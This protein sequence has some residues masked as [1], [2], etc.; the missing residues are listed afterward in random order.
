MI[1]QE[2]IKISIKP[3]YSLYSLYSKNYDSKVIYVVNNF[4]KQ[5]KLYLLFMI[6]NSINFKA[7]IQKFPKNY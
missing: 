2:N 6:K 7:G 1:W 5:R 3:I 4:Y